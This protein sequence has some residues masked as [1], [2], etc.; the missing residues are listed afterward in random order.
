MFEINRDTVYVRG[1]KNG[2]IYD[3]HTE[4]VY[5]MNEIACDIIDRY[6]AQKN[7]PKDESY[8][9]VLESNNLISKD[10]LPHPFSVPQDD[11]VKLEMA[12]IEVTQRC[13]L[14]CVHCYEG[15]THT[16]VT[17]SLSLEDWKRVIYELG[18]L[19]INRLIIIGGEPCCSS[20]VCEIMEYAASFS[21][22][23]TL[24]TNATL[25][26]EDIFQCIVKNKIN[27]KVSIYGPCA[28]VHDSITSVPGSFEKTTKMI[29]R[30]IDAGIK[31]SSAFIV[32]KENEDYVNETIDFIKK[33]GMK[34]SRYDVIR[35]V[36]GGTQNP[37]VPTRAD[38]VKP[39]HFTK[40]NFRITKQ[41]FFHNALH[42]T[43]W[44]GKIAIM[45]NGNVIP[46]EF[47]RSFV[48][49]NVL[50]ESIKDIITNEKTRS[51]WFFSFEQI[52]ECK[53]C[54]FR[55][56]CKD[57]RPLGISVC[58]QINTKNPRCHYD[59]YNGEW[60]TI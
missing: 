56:A 35:Q 36:W 12:W 6:I 15:N 14:R 28:S 33:T 53:D 27:V 55:Y 58:G 22:D 11:E 52:E 24:F 17:K 47:E 4:N 39:V 16:S 29:R 44:Y 7:T 18:C 20:M 60:N 46:C 30:L 19:N 42:N 1:A 21:M 13:N 48:Y 38:V 9:Q 50:D 31:V 26:S 32:M 23:I 41:K 40:P 25:I 49:G 5:S 43:C 2:A 54:E 45:E 57:C 3:F 37:H 59:V 8:L 51:K 34:Y 10:F